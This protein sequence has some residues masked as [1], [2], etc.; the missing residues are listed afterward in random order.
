MCFRCR[1]QC[2]HQAAQAGGPG[3]GLWSSCGR[4]TEHRLRP[5]QAEQR[6]VAHCVFF[7]GL[8]KTGAAHLYEQ[9]RSSSRGLRACSWVLLQ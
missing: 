7:Y 6:P 3:G 1:S 4:L 8:T 5:K 9:L 2:D